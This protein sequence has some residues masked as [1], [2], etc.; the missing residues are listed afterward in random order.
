MASST[1]KTIPILSQFYKMKK[2]DI[3]KKL[4]PVD[5]LDFIN[6]IEE[7]HNQNSGD[8]FISW[9]HK[10]LSESLTLFKMAADY[11]KE[12]TEYETKF[13]TPDTYTTSELDKMKT[14]YRTVKSIF[15]SMKKSAYNS[16]EIVHI[17]MHMKTK[18][19]YSLI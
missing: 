11:Y 16:L 2:N 9:L 10:H 7:L 19:N 13:A 18:Y 6:V 17:N 15:E 3:E 14:H 12:I 4:S 1:I 5:V 8:E